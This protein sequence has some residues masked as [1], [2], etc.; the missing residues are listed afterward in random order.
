[1]MDQ[2]TGPQSTIVLHE[3]QQVDNNP[4]KSF[5]LLMGA[6]LIRKNQEKVFA[7]GEWMN[8]CQQSSN[9]REVP[10]VLK[11]LLKFRQELIQQQLIGILLLT[12]K[13][14]TM[15]CHNKSKGSISI[16]RLVDK[17]FK[18]A[19]Q[20]NRTIEAGHIPSLS[21]T[22][23]D[24]LPRLSR[25]GDYVIT[26][27]IL[28]KTLKELGIQVSINVLATRE[29]RQCVRTRPA[30]RIPQEDPPIV[31]LTSKSRTTIDLYRKLSRRYNK[32]KCSGNSVKNQQRALTALLKFMRY[33]KQQIH[34]Y[35]I[36]QLMRKIRMRLRQTDKE[37]QI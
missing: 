25:C 34:S 11:A 4:D 27:D 37:K 33:S 8:N 6:T 17:L 7:H 14:V 31:Q 3:T 22:I 15:N 23:P 26:R 1:M 35:L 36:K 24:S 12:D 10:T 28:L 21:S 32:F 30:S 5:E 18:L 13:T 9:Q 2:Q 19:E 20:Y 16:F 29:N